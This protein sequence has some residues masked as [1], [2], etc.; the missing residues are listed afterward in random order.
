MGARFTGRRQGAGSRRIG[1]DVPDMAPA[2]ESLALPAAR[3]IFHP[4]MIAPW[5]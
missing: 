5:A 1:R 3:G 2:R 4:G